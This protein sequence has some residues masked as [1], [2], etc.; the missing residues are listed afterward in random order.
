MPQFDKALLDQRGNALG[1]GTLGKV[2]EDGWVHIAGFQRLHHKGR[3]VVGGGWSDTRCSA[4][5]GLGTQ[6]G[7][8]GLRSLG[9]C[10]CGLFSLAGFL[11]LGVR[12]GVFAILGQ[13]HGVGRVW[14]HVRRWR[15]CL[16]CVLGR[17]QLGC[18]VGAGRCVCGCS[19]GHAACVRQLGAGIALNQFQELGRLF[20]GHHA[21]LRVLLEKLCLLSC[22]HVCPTTY[23]RGRKGS[24][25]SGEAGQ[26]LAPARSALQ[27]RECH[28]S[29]GCVSPGASQRGA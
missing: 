10:P 18:L 28:P 7:Q 21:V 17:F 24:E 23:R 4:L 12:D 11:Q 2:P 5:L 29:Q 8:F 25:H 13:N 20:R 15:G 16:A 3:S 26:G 27:L 14:L 19:A 9:G 22:G 6:S 1:H